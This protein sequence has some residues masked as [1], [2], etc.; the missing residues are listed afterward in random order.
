MGYFIKRFHEVT[1]IT[2]IVPPSSKI[3]HHIVGTWGSCS[4]VER[5]DINPNCFY[6]PY[7]YYILNDTKQQSLHNFAVF[8]DK[9]G[10]SIKEMMLPCQIP[11]IVLFC[12]K[13]GDYGSSGPRFK[14][15]NTRL[16]TW[17]TFG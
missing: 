12:E 8:M 13:R 4:V 2:S 3:S 11:E 1:I 7:T 6:F 9:V 17:I 15:N 5:P 10:N 16:G 14:L